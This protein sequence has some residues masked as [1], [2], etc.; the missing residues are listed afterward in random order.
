MSRTVALP[1]PSTMILSGLALAAA[2]LTGAAVADD[3]I[4]PD[5]TMLKFP[6]VSDDYIVFVYANDIWRVPRDG[7]TAVSLASPPGV[8]LFP[9]FS[10]PVC[11]RNRWCT[12]RFWR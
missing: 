3:G 11:P 9:R 10:C 6:D 8:E 1:S 4:R 5:A 7:G 12:R 2:P